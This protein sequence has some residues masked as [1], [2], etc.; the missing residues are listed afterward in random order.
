MTTFQKNR[1]NK[2]KCPNHPDKRGMFPC[3]ICG[4]FVCP[5]CILEDKGLKYC[6]NKKCREEADRCHNHPQ[7]ASFS[8]CFVCEQF[9]CEDCLIEVRE[10]EIGG[11]K[12]ISYVCKN[13]KD[14][15]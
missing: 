14:Y 2:G 15:L 11:Q 13:E 12:Y 5:D 4:R 3:A 1:L 8:Y 9:Y 6:N 10:E 7:K